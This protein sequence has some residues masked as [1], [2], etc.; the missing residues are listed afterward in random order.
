MNSHNKIIAVLLFMVACAP[1]YV[2][3]A[4]H[5]HD[6]VHTRQMQSDRELY[7]ACRELR[8][9]LC[10]KEHSQIFLREV[11]L[12]RELICNSELLEEIEKA[13][14]CPR[15]N[16]DQQADILEKLLLESTV[17]GAPPPVADQ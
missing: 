12:R 7:H 11:D 6:E 10:N 5:G 17:Q 8:D 3:G 4:D 2:R 14:K 13:E 15:E 16:Q 1:S 9:T